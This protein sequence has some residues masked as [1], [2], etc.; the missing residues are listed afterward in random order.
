[1]SHHHSSRLAV[2]GTAALLASVLSSGAFAQPGQQGN[3]ASATGNPLAQSMATTS[4]SEPNLLASVGENAAPGG[5]P[6]AGM[7]RVT[8]STAQGVPS[9]AGN[10]ASPTELKS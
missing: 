8:R 4:S 5:N 7:S 3:G 10:A 2:L 6:A 9:A 1:M